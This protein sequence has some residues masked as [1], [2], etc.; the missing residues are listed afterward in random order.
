[1]P[2][3]NTKKRVIIKKQIEQDVIEL[4]RE[5]RRTLPREGTRKLMR[6]LK[7]EFNKY[8]LKEGRDQLFHI[9]RDNSLLIRRENT[10]VEP[11]IHITGFTNME[12]S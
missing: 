1:M 4:V 5:S 3:T 9:L 7:D 2:I 8:D 6:S 12:I 11:P 10:L